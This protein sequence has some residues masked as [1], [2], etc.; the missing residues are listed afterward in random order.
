MRKREGEKTR[1]YTKKPW[2]C[3]KARK[4]TSELQETPCGLYQWLGIEVLIR[5][6]GR[7]TV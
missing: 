6:L 5:V 7:D 3:D 4:A 1:S 2:L